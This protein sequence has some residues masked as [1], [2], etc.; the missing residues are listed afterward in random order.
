MLA[1][2]RYG[3]LVSL[4]YTIAW[5]DRYLRGTA[6]SSIAE[7]AF[8]RLTAPVFDDSADIHNI[9]QGFYDP[10]AALAS[11]NLDAGNVPYR[12]EGMPTSNRLS[13][14]FRSKCD[15]GVPG[16]DTR[17]RSN[18]MRATACTA[19]SSTSGGAGGL[20]LLAI[21]VLAGIARGARRL[22]RSLAT[23]RPTP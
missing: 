6:D 11:A 9:S 19:T 2:S 3:E 17:A 7:D 21:G 16:S 14:Y 1:T 10:I 22:H 15:I 23:G 13:F 4:Y 5:F 12:L 18:N 8:A 20:L